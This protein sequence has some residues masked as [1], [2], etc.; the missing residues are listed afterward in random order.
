MKLKYAALGLSLLAIVQIIVLVINVD[1]MSLLKEPL[2]A[3][4]NLAGK[5]PV[6]ILGM[7]LG[8]IL[9][10]YFIYLLYKKENIII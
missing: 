2:S 6:F 8:M 5:Y 7:G 4:G 3:F 9:F 1:T 10:T